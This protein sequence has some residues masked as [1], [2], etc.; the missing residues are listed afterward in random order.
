MREEYDFSKRKRGVYSRD[1]KDLHFPV[2]LDPQLEEY[3]KN[4]ALKK[5]K[6]LSTIINTILQKEMELHDS[7]I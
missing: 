2:Y 7:L 4:I 6:D 5:N 1:L 3:Y